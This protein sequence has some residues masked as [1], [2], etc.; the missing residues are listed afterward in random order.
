MR[1]YFLDFEEMMIRTGDVTIKTLRGG[2]GAPLLLLHGHPETHLMW[3]NVAGVLS[4]YFTVVVTDLRGYGESSHPKGLPDHS[5]YSR[6]E[7]GNDQNEVMKRLGYNSYYLAGHD[8]GAR[9]AHRMLYDHAENIKKCMILDIVPTY[10]MYKLTDR[11][12]ATGYYHWFF[13]IQPNG[14]PEN[15]IGDSGEAFVRSFLGP[16]G[17]PETSERIFPEEIKKEYVRQLATREGIHSICEDYRACATIDLEHDEKDRDRMIDVPVHVLWGEKNYLA[18]F[19][20]VLGLWK[21]RI[22]Q[23]TGACVP[24][25]GHFIP[26]DAPEVTV[27]AMLEFFRTEKTA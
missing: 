23:V 14:L 4:R 18:E 6:R 11:K 17:D 20:D 24:D 25:C 1:K 9:V 26:E 8:R 27:N 10:D 3:R 7:M 12:F 22:S 5:N 21:A 2:Q 15:I 16:S 13:L 19:Y